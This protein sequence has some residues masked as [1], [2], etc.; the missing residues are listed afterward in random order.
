MH[1][2]VVKPSH[3]D[4]ARVLADVRAWLARDPE[5]Q[6]ERRKLVKVC[7]APDPPA[8]LLGAPR[9]AGISTCRAG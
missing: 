3:E 9:P 1:Y 5:M 2:R 7:C 6:R 4:A 8:H